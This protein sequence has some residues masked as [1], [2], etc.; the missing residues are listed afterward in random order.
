MVTPLDPAHLG[1]SP[2]YTALAPFNTCCLGPATPL[3]YSPFSL[4]RGPTL[5]KVGKVT[6]LVMDLVARRGFVGRF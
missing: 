3:V 4:L 2:L 1:S 5:P 6:I